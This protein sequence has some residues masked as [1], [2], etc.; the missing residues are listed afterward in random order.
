MDAAGE[1]Q[2]RAA[3]AI[4]ERIE[5]TLPST[6][7]GVGEVEQAAELL[8][9]RAG[10]DEDTSCNIAMVIR[11]AAINATKHGNRFAPEKKVTAALERT[12]G[13]LTARICDEGEGLDPATLPDPLDPANLLRD[14]GRGV[15]LMRALMDEVHFRQLGHGTEVTLIKYRNTEAS[16]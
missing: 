8:A 16:S 12:A 13:R 11:E 14:S 3:D 4:L 5:L 7:D 15:F 6:L 10:F 1:K 2:V 9:Q